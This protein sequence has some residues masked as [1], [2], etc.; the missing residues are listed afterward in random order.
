LINEN[1][2][3]EPSETQKILIA[4]KLLENLTTYRRAMAY[5]SADVPIQALCLPPN[6]EKILLDH[7]C[8]RVYDMIDLDLTKIKG[9]GDVRIRYLTAC[10]DQF[11][12]IG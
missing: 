5:M 9:L 10:L 1:L 12:S 6:L 2:N 7:G 4:E 11:L 8:L 3:S